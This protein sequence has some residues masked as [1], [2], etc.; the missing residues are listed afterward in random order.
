[1]VVQKRSEMTFQKINCITTV[2][3]GECSLVNTGEVHRGYISD[4]PFASGR[5]KHA[6]DV[7]L[8]TL[9]CQIIAKSL[10]FQLSSDEQSYIAKRFYK[11]NEYDD[12][13]SVPVDKNKVEIQGELIRLVLG[14]W[15]LDCF[16]RFCKTHKDSVSVD[17]SRH[18]SALTDQQLN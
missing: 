11:L 9:F 14:K 12:D 4:K 3:T 2:A 18:L 1:M 15:F 10:Q 7:S 6:Y 17:L 13:D 16:Y 8:S 5:M